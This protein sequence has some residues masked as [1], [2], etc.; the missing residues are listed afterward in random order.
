MSSIYAKELP[1]IMEKA[2]GQGERTIVGTKRKVV[3][4]KRE[5]ISPFM[6]TWMDLKDIMLSEKSQTEKDK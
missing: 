1:L 5:G 2:H 3:G 6:T 4:Q